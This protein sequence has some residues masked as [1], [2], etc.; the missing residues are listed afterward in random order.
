MKSLLSLVFILAGYT[1][2]CQST[3]VVISEV[4]GGGGATSGTVPF[5]NDY[6]ELYNMTDKDIEMKEWSVQYNSATGTNAYQFN[7]FSGIIKAKS[8]YLIQLGG[9]NIGGELPTPD[10]TGSLN[11]SATNGKVA[12]RNTNTALP[13]NSPSVGEG[14]ID[15]VGY[16]SANAFEGTMA[17]SVLTNATALERKA[18]A[19]STEETMATGGI[20][21]QKG[22]GFD[23]NNN[24]TDF[25]RISK[26]D[27]QNSK[28]P[29]EG[30]TTISP[31]VVLS[32]SSVNFG[33]VS[34]GQSSV[35][36]NIKLITANLTKN[37]TIKVSEYFLVG[38]TLAGPFNDSISFSSSE[39]NN[40]RDLYLIF[41][42]VESG[43]ATG[44]LTV[45]TSEL[46]NGIE[47]NLTGIGLQAGEYLFDFANCST[48]LSDGFTQFSSKGDQVW[49]CTTFGRDATDPNGKANKAGAIQISGFQTVA[50]EN[51][52]W[53]LSPQLQIGANP[54][55]F[56]TLS[57]YSRTRFSG[58]PLELKISENYTPGLNPKA[59]EVE[60]ESVDAKFP[61]ADSDTWTLTPAL[62][63]S[64]YR[65][66]K[67][68]LAWVYQ[69]T[70]SDAPRWTIDD[71]KVENASN[72]VSGQLSLSSKSIYFGYLPVNSIA[73][74]SFKIEANPYDDDI[75]LSVSAPY[76]LSTNKSSYSEVLE[77]KSNQN[78]INNTVYIRA[79]P[80]STDISYIDTVK[81]KVDQK[82]VSKIIVNSNTIDP[83]KTLDVVS[84]NIE[85]FGGMNG[86]VND[87]L[88]IAN[89][90]RLLK[91]INADVLGLT[92]IIDTVALKRMTENLGVNKDEF[93]YFVSKYTSNASN[94]A[95]ANYSSG[96]KLAFVYRTKNVKPIQIEPLFYTSDITSPAYNNW[97]SGRF[98]LIMRAEITLS[99]MKKEIHFI[100]IHGK[101]QNSADAHMRRKNAAQ[102]LHEYIEANLK[103]KAV[104]ILG[105]YNDD[106]DETVGSLIQ[107]GADWPKSSYE[108]F[109]KDTSKYLPVTLPLSL[110]KETST[111]RF[112]E[113][114]DHIILTNELQQ[115]YIK[116]STQVLDETSNMILNYSTTT[117]DHYPVLTRLSFDLISNLNSEEELSAISIYPNPSFGIYIIEGL[118]EPAL[119]KVFDLSGRHHITVSVES[120]NSTFSL[121]ELQSGTY[122]GVLENKFG[123]RMVRLVKM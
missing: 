58:K 17:A 61:V 55:T 46:T 39:L 20:D 23:T 96:Q 54:S 29:S 91:N 14:I 34:G 16:G 33:N 72:P 101:A 117:S 4:Y 80:K 82:I 62:D 83:E 95:S 115:S 94:P 73:I 88:Q 11:L 57:F 98:P 12:L 120:E 26:P 75:T 18:N 81:I 35:P 19:T 116:N 32:S 90:T 64:K 7:V 99:G 102:S 110:N 50:N 8:Y 44:K 111:A 47:A 68:T 84:Y 51:E 112:S 31:S 60:W 6:V 3:T 87:S 114:I 76:S 49:G 38:K 103:D 10:F 77:I 107:V 79:N 27:P 122:L 53:L 67:I 24:S 30:S 106:L 63:L 92:E 108:V 104:V 70:S 109:T 123:I 15:F 21:A 66:K 71:V 40:T 2:F 25:V 9:G 86:P 69:S 48:T 45:S 97:T 1:M 52:D 37:V 41:T 22:N 56:P 100:L 59:S 42:P 118:K 93:G 5:K 121:D 113:M 13:A 78:K 36:V 28:S 65:G 119:L 43:T 85:W 105:D 89:T 74:D